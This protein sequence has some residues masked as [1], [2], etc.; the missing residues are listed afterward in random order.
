MK[1]I[2][3]VFIALNN[4]SVL[5]TPHKQTIPCGKLSFSTR[6]CALSVAMPQAL[7][8]AARTLTQHLKLMGVSPNC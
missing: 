3:I 1:T 5:N 6:G 7:R 8:N 4:I 2:D